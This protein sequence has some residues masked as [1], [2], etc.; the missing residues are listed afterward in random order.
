MINVLFGI[1]NR[2]EYF[3]R[4]AINVILKNPDT[5]ETLRFR[6][7]LHDC[8][9]RANNAYT[10]LTGYHAP[11]IITARQLED[12]ILYTS[13]YDEVKAKIVQYCSERDSL[14][15]LLLFVAIT[16]VFKPNNPVFPDNNHPIQY[17]GGI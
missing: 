2:M 14:Y 11:K 6:S 3:A 12:I 16:N 13:S 8:L 9:V 1:W 5:I 4:T 7:K 10:A 17:L 15:S